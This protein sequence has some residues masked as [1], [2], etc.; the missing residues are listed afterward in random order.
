MSEFSRVIAFY[1]DDFTGA[2]DTLATAARGGLRTM[3]FLHPPTAAQRLAAGALDCIG[4]AGAARAMGPQ[5]M[6][7]ELRAVAAC[8]SE[9]KPALVH[10]KTCSTFDSAPQIGSIGLAVRILKTHLA[11]QPFVPII[12]GQ[13][14]LGRYCLFGNLYAVQQAGGHA[15]RIDRHPTMRSHPVTPMGEAD[16]SLHFAKQGLGPIGVVQYPVYA[17]S[18]DDIARKVDEAQADGAQA[19]L[20]DVGEESHLATIGL[21]LQRALASVADARPLMAV[22]PSSVMQALLKRASSTQKIAQESPALAEARGGVLVLCGSL[23]PMSAQQVAASASYEHIELDVTA[24]SE[25]NTAYLSTTATQIAELLN[26]GRHV[27]A[28]TG[29]PRADDA[30]VSGA[31]LAK[32]CGQLLANILAQATPR[33]IGLA[34]GDTSSYAVKALDIW[35]LSYAQALAPGVALC[36][37]HADDPR[38][39]GIELMLKGGQMG[40]ADLFERLLGSA[41]AEA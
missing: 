7:A 23:S 38:L 28:V 22:G 33:R 15:Y 6:E 34:G 11:V 30:P 35:G 25:G 19:V 1:G 20:F 10:Y 29:S 32:A 21:I 2:T 39:D 13:P 37:T 9:I 3:L 12:G 26:L 5:E 40:G 8:W 14:N 36:R 18:G 17:Q 27:L 4:I 41:E 16:L 31:T 24:L